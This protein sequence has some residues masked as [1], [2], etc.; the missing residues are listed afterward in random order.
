MN[1]ILTCIGGVLGAQRILNFKKIKKYKKKLSIIGL[2]YNENINKNLCDYFFKVGYGSSK[3]FISDVLQ[4]VKDFKVNLIIPGSDE[5]ALNLSRNSLLF[6]KLNCKI[7]TSDLST[8]KII[9]DKEKT[10]KFLDKNNLSPP[11]WTISQNKQNLIKNVE[12]LF[13]DG[14]SEIIVKPSISRGSRNIFCISKKDNYEKDFLFPTFSYKN[15]KKFLNKIPTNQKLISMEKYNSDFYDCDIYIKR[16]KVINMT[17]RKRLNKFLPNNGNI[18]IKIED[19][20]KKLILKTSNLLNLNSIHDFDLMLDRNGNYKIIEINPRMSGSLCCSVMAGASYYNDIISYN[21]NK[22][23]HGKKAK[24]GSKVIPIT[25]L[26][27][28]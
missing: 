24:Q 28:V 12:Y 15:Y 22:T 25:K 4:I 3:K 20:L 13:N 9:S 1:I 2:D 19:K 11:K 14:I 26:I 21:I 16:G 8:L 27:T 17:L 5:E 18:I 6:Q 23:F 7:E 10:Y